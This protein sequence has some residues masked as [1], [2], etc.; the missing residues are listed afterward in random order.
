[1]PSGIRRARR[2]RRR[3][4]AVRAGDQRDQVG[5]HRRGGDELVRARAAPG[6]RPSAV[7]PL[8]TTCQCAG[9]VTVKVKVGLQ[10]GL[11][12]AGEKPFG[13]GGLELGVQVDGAVDGVDEAVQALAGVQ[14]EA[15][16]VDDQLVV[17]GQSAQR[18]AGGLV[19][20][21][22]VDVGPLRVAL[23][24][25]SAAKSTKVSAPASASNSSGRQRPEGALAGLAVAVGEVELDAVVVD[26]DQRCAFAGLV[27]S[28]IGKCHASS[29][30][31]VAA[32]VRPPSRTI[33]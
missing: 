16:G 1:M 18:D 24:I 27:V 3:A 12:E 28:Q 13:V 9:A 19:V 7:A 4:T 2:C 11:V 25:V 5:A 14:V 6:P 30:L 31:I 23:R 33:R 10:V 15:D 21:A 17:F 29:K 32:R 22:N 26:G 20:A 8:D